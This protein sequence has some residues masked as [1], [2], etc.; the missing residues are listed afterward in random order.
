MALD[1]V[2]PFEQYQ[3]NQLFSETHFCTYSL[4]FQHLS[5]FYLYYRFS[6]CIRTL[7]GLNSCTIGVGF[8]TPSIEFLPFPIDRQQKAEM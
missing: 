4:F 3:D 7:V 1:L 2:N 8:Q 5:L 6:S